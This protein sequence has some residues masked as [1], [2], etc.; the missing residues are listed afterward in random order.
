MDVTVPRD[1]L[2]AVREDLAEIQSLAES[3]LD[4]YAETAAALDALLCW[5]ET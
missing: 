4:Q 2:I 3:M 1:E 5:P